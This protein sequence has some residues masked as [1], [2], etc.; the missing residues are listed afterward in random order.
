MIRNKD[1]GKAMTKHISCDFKRKF[2]SVTCNSSRKQNNKICQC[3]CKNYYK[4]EKDYSSNPITCICENSKYLKS[5][6]DTSVT[7]RDKIVVVMNNL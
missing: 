7:N 5:V 3:E 4:C 1:K 2:N 6:A